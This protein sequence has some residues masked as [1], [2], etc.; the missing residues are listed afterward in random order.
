MSVITGKRMMDLTADPIPEL[1]R[2]LAV[3]AS[4][5]M[6]FNT[7]FNVVDTYFAGYLSTDG[8][9]AISLTFP[10]FFIILAIGMGIGTG[11]TAL[12]ANA[13]GRKDEK[14]A[15]TYLRQALV[16][17]VLLALVV[18]GAGFASIRKLFLL[19][20]A[21]GAVLGIAIEYMQVILI[22]GVFF[23]LNYILNAALSARGDNASFRNVLIIASILNV[24]LDPL[25]L[26]G[27]KPLGIPAMGA[28]GIALSTVVVQV[29]GTIYLTARCI[30]CGYFRGLAGRHWLPE[31]KVYGEIAKQGFPAAIN[32]ATVAIGIFVITYFLGLFG[33]KEAIAAYGVAVR[34]EQIA[35]LPTAGLNTALLA[36]TGQNVGAGN[37][38]RVRKALSV[39]LRYGAYIMVVMLGLIIP[40]ADR[41]VRVFTDDPV[42]ITIAKTYLYLAVPAFYS[43][44]ILFTSVSLLQGMKKPFF[45]LWIGVY[46]QIIAPSLAFYLLGR[47]AGL[48]VTGIWIGIIIV[49]WSAALYS[50]FYAR[51]TL[52]AAPA[53]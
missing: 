41:L 51:R 52:A 19:L 45:A 42:V 39:V 49:N 30:R 46:R 40:F 35:L 14:S 8:L 24:G 29:F 25:F 6:F 4:T 5:G 28:A 18:V 38:E 47:V 48:G 44:V 21:E 13:L 16:F 10:V 20:H 3:P 1:V 23:F 53:V 12:I 9:A 43:Y 17:G 15:D 33:A 11:T 7:M 34:I 36:L 37:I 22:G 32:M 27:S 26:L 31:P 50:L 2:R